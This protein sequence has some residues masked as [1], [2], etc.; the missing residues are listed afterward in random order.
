[1]S[2]TQILKNLGPHS[3][4][5]HEGT[6]W[7]ILCRARHNGLVSRKKA[8]RSFFY[9]LTDGGNRRVK[10]ILG[11]KVKVMKIAANPKGRD[12]V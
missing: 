3:E 12:E 8:G 6:I 1:M 5:T 9:E 11:K 7:T 2:A 4:G 10:W